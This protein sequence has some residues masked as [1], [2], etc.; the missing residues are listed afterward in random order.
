MKINTEVDYSTRDYEGFRND[1]IEGLQ[2]RIPEY[3]DTSQSDAGIVILELLAHGLDLLSYYNDKTANEVYLDTAKERSNIINIAKMMGYIYDDGRP[4]E[5]E[6][7]FEIIPQATEFVIPQGYV[8][9]TTE[10]G[11][12][13]EV[14]FETK[15]ELRIP[16]NCT[17]LEQDENGKYL[18]SVPITQGYTI[19]NEIIGSSDGT[20]NQSF[21]LSEAP[22]IKDSVLVTVKQ[23]NDDEEEW[24]RVDKFLNSSPYDTH[25]TV[26]ISATDKGIV[27]FGNGKSGKIPSSISDGIT[28]TYRVGGGEIGNV[29]PLSINQVDQKLAGLVRTF[30]PYNAMTLGVDKEDDESI[31]SKA[32]SSFKSTWGAITLSDYEDIARTFDD[33]VDA[34]STT[35]DTEFDVIVYVLPRNYDD[36][37]EHELDVIFNKLAKVYLARKILG[38][39]VFI[40]FATKVNIHPSIQVNLHS[41]VLKADIKALIDN[42]IESTF[43]GNTRRLGESLHPSEI[44]AELM[45]INGVKSVTCTIEDLPSEVQSNEVLK[46]ESYDLSLIGGL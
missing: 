10:S 6:Q 31:K 8:V 28:A 45:T 3:T 25:F 43:K 44:I 46:I 30:N 24:I 41:N 11:V 29:S 4:S 14:L 35:G 40:R 20:I 15:E 18:Y 33:V 16:P 12:E 26:S 19:Y 1:M 2:K 7:V 42:I 27:N 39:E 22:V 17:G 13:K 37:S 21:T 36:L 38:V 5:F 32:K 9:K 23:G 34:I